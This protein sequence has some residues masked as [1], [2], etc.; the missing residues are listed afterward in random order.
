MVGVDLGL[1]E[2]HRPA[3]RRR[4]VAHLGHNLADGGTTACSRQPDHF[5]SSYRKNALDQRVLAKSRQRYNEL[6]FVSGGIADGPSEHGRRPAPPGHHAPRPCCGSAT[7]AGIGAPLAVPR[8]GRRPNGSGVGQGA[9]LRHAHRH[10][11]TDERV[12]C[13]ACQR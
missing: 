8:P 6:C 1:L 2:G 10:D 13:P 9:P 11:T 12:R 5:G 7:S 4:V 3:Q